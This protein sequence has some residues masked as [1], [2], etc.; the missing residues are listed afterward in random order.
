MAEATD[1][2]LLDAC[3]EADATFTARRCVVPATSVSDPA[4]ASSSVDA[5]E[6]RSMIS[7]TAASNRSA[8]EFMSALRCAAR[9]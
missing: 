1:W 3:V 7:P 2:T 9:A 4:A 5:D 6:T 8:S